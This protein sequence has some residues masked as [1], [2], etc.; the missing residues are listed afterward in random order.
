MEA[1][2]QDD[3]DDMMDETLEEGRKSCTV[4]LDNNVVAC[5]YI[6]YR[7]IGEKV[8]ICFR[9]DRVFDNTI[10]TLVM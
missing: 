8:T 2:E 1:E 5:C 3:D 7:Y 4:T 6:L 10:I 9:T